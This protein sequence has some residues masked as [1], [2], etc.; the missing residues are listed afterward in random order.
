ML[1]REK[2]SDMLHIKLSL[3]ADQEQPIQF[4]WG[5]ERDAK[6][7]QTVTYIGAVLSQRS[8]DLLLELAR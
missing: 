3:V 8:T 1:P 7:I 4:E 2:L 6:I 5:E